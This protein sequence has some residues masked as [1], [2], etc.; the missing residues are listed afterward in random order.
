MT[1]SHLIIAA[2]VGLASFL[3]SRTVY[4]RLSLTRAER[5]FLSVAADQG[6]ERAHAMDFVNLARAKGTTVMEEASVEAQA[7]RDNELRETRK[8]AHI[9][10]MERAAR[11]EFARLKQESNLSIEEMSQAA[12]AAGIAQL[13]RYVGPG[14]PLE[15]DSPLTTNVDALQA[16]IDGC[17]D[18]LD[19]IPPSEQYVT[20]LGRAA[21]RTIKCE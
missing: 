7:M 11:D 5:A 8:W 6:M 20:R 13:N 21:G 3:A 9:A 16:L 14:G 17:N 1:G 12:D 2:L 10:V 15:D 18:D 19:G 4:R